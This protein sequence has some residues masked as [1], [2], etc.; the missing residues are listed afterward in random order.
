MSTEK[1]VC[2]DQYWN[3]VATPLFIFVLLFGLFVLF[4]V[5]GTQLVAAGPIAGVMAAIKKPLRGYAPNKPPVAGPLVARA[6]AA[7]ANA[8]TTAG[9]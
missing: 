2:M 4:R 9:K 6:P 7:A 1:E 3:Y 8:T 5:S